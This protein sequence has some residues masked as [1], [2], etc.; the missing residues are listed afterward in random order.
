MR[1]PPHLSRLLLILC[2]PLV[3]SCAA[4]QSA[5]F[6]SQLST[7]LSRTG[8]EETKPHP[9]VWQAQENPELADPDE[10]LAEDL[11]PPESEATASQEI[12]DLE[13]LG[14]WEE[15]SSPLANKIQSDFPLTIN[16]QVEYYLDLFQNQQRNIFA[17]W[18]TRSGRYLPM[19]QK[20]SARR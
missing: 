5:T 17:S 1:L 15:I 8:S 7:E 20:Q 14:S 3:W 13:K 6:Q 4:Q 18:L 16:R 10:Q 19:M 11:T 12:K 9:E 2:L